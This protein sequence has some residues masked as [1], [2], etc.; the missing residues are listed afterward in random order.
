MSFS[1][2]CSVSLSFPLQLVR[3][4]QVVL[5]KPN[6]PY[7]KMHQPFKIS[8]YRSKSALKTLPDNSRSFFHEWKYLDKQ[9]DELSAKR[10]L[11]WHEWGNACVCIALGARVQFIRV[12]M[13]NDESTVDMSAASAAL[14]SLLFTLTAT[15][16]EYSRR[17]ARPGKSNFP[18]F[19]LVARWIFSL[20]P[21]ITRH[22]RRDRWPCCIVS[23]ARIL[24]CWRFADGLRCANFVAGNLHLPS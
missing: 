10:F 22:F 21:G 3:L 20:G 6:I 8:V 15:C 4:G 5:D 16:P 11:A 13:A 19:F 9:T 23:L 24:S 14:E 2:R 12:F 1:I 7:E 18:I 17:P